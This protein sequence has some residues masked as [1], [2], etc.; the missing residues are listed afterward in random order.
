MRR[1]MLRSNDAH[2]HTHMAHS[3]V[4][5]SAYT[6]I[7]AAPLVFAGICNII[8]SNDDIPFNYAAMRA[9][10]TARK[11]SYTV[12]VQCIIIRAL[13]YR[14]YIISGEPCRACSVHNLFIDIRMPGIRLKLHTTALCYYMKRA[15]WAA[16]RSGGM[17]E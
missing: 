15:N 6:R 14:V 2:T 4:G 9:T 13:E 3:C 11:Q 10:C 16:C 8:T 7:V 12:I 1:R 17:L 5:I